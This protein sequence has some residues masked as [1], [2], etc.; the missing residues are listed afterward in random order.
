M[1]A[2]FN[3]LEVFTELLISLLV[4]LIPCFIEIISLLFFRLTKLIG[5]EVEAAG[6]TAV[7]EF[8]AC[9]QFLISC[10]ELSFNTE[11]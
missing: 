8:G 4:G 7:L 5:A 9:G 6:G 2:T 1:E 11:K 3:S 10:K